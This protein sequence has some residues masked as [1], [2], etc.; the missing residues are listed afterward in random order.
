MALA[1]RRREG[2]RPLTL[3]IVAVGLLMTRFI[4][5]LNL[6]PQ[7]YREVIMH[8]ATVVGLALDV[9][10]STSIQSP[11]VGGLVLGVEQSTLIESPL[12]IVCHSWLL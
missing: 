9:E 10:Q 11:L 2:E 4:V 5:G 8:C 1:R 7:E 3:Y 6:I 12:M